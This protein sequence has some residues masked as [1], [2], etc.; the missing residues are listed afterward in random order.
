MD[1]PT[2]VLAISRQFA[3][4][5]SYIGQAVARRLGM[6]YADRDVLARA[7]EESGL[8]EEDLAATEERAASLWNGFFGQYA[9]GAPEAPFVVPLPPPVRERD[10]F[11]I[12]SRIIRE[13]AARSDA[14]IVGRAGFHVL[15]GHPGLISIRI[16][17][18]EEWRV[19]RA[20]ES[21]GIASPAEARELIRRSDQQRARFVRS[22]TGHDWNDACTH[23]LCLDTSSVGLDLA[24]DLVAALVAGRMKEQGAPA[25]TGR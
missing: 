24:T 8:S 13:I 9:L 16:H 2:I 3:S 17:A 19:E 11:R 6:R 21:Y 1:R 5:G 25:A 10:V 7:A 4:G 22:F 15:A 12:E 14:V 18:R 23:H 20:M